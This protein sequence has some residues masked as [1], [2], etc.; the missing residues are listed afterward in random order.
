MG[1]CKDY[2]HCKHAWNNPTRGPIW[3]EFCSCGEGGHRIRAGRAQNTGKEAD[4]PK[5]E[6]SC[7]PRNIMNKN[8]KIGKQRYPVFKGKKN[9]CRVINQNISFKSGVTH[10][11]T[12]EAKGMRKL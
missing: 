2:M 3:W 5:A 8:E 4:S 7:T 11:E 12:K 9:Q 6:M 10:E 1:G